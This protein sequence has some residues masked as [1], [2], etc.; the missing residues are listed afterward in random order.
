MIVIREFFDKNTGTI[1]YIVHDPSTKDSIVI[2]PVL[3]F[4]V[5]LG[6]YT[7]HSF[8]EQLAY[9]KNN[10]L[11][12]HFVL[13]TH[14]HADHISSSQFFKKDFSNVKVA[15]S[16]HITEVQEVFN[17]LFQ[18]T[19]AKNDGT[20]F[21]KLITD[22]EEF[23]AGS[24]NIKAISTPGHTP[25]CISFL[26]ENNI[27][28]GDSIFIP[29]AGTGRCDFPKGDATTLFKSVT[30]KLYTLPDTTKVFVGHNYPKNDKAP[31]FQTSI[32]ELKENNIHITK[33]TQLKDFLNFREARDKEL[34][35]P[36]LLFQSIQINMN[37]GKFNVDEK[38]NAFLK[39]PMFKG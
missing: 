11:Q 32:K 23:K 33:D 21:D 10:Q 17:K 27:F 25:A 14:I 29:E 37:A 5:N 24:I 20:D 1:S 35:A 30:Q 6:T 12:L 38:G 19:N 28:V 18:F 4:N 16:K 39:M 8:E 2:D 9:L 31:H 36:K 26:V 7:T 3:N 22:N 34:N 13:E 15:I